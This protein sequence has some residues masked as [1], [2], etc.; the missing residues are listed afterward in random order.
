[1]NISTEPLWIFLGVLVTALVNMVL[2]RRKAHVDTNA[3]LYVAVNEA[4]KT[5]T[6]SLFRQIKALE[7]S[8]ESLRTELAQCTAKHQESERRVS[9]LEHEVQELHAQLNSR[10]H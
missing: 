1:M 4:T 7:D 8:V 10:L 9:T 5:L 6:E 2:A 3:A